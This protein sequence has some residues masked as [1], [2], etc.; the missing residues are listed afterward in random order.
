[1]T[2]YYREKEQTRIVKT[3]YFSSVQIQEE[4]VHSP[5]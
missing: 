5:P 3:K 1:M 4:K 2:E